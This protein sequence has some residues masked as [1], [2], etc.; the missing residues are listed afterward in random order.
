MDKTK[1]RFVAVTFDS[2]EEAELDCVA[3]KAIFPDGSWVELARRFSDEQ[4][5]LSA[6]RQ[7]V[8]RPIASNCANVVSETP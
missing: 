3:I 4:L 1:L 2:F 8:I 6:K 5:V 7:L